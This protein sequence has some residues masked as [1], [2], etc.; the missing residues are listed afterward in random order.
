[1]SKHPLHNLSIDHPAIVA[2][3]LDVTLVPANRVHYSS[4]VLGL[5]DAAMER[6]RQQ[7]ANAPNSETPT[8]IPTRTPPA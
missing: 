5:A 6:I 8:D 3:A 7:L 4:L 1:M 2:I